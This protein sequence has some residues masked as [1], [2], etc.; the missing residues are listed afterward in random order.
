LISSEKVETDTLQS[1]WNQIL[2]FL[3]NSDAANIA[4]VLGVVISLIGF[5]LTLWGVM[6]SKSAAKA[7][8][9][10]AENTQNS[11]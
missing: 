9:S 2:G 1:Y 8:K 11:I 10:A 6:R 3:G 5:S 7:A 4:S